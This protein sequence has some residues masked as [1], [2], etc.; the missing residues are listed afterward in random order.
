MQPNIIGGVTSSVVSRI[1]LEVFVGFPAAAF[2]PGTG[3]NVAINFFFGSI[4]LVLIAPHV[5]L[6]AFVIVVVL[7]ILV[8]FRLLIGSVVSVGFVVFLIPQI[9]ILQSA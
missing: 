2:D 8:I 3:K 1:S 9:R 5:V 6:V 4:A 7:I